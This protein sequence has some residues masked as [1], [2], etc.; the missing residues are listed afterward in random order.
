M[1]RFKFGAETCFPKLSIIFSKRK[2]YIY[3]NLNLITRMLT[4]GYLRND[5]QRRGDEVFAVTIT[6]NI[7]L[8]NREIEFANF[9]KRVAAKKI[10]SNFTRAILDES[11]YN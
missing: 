7:W 2:N 3:R 9:E 6:D 4:A 11:C 10:F 1:Y 8:I 5:L